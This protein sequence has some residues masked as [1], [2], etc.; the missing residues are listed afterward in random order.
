MALSEYP[1]V[2]ELKE[3]V[4]KHPD[5]VITRDDSLDAGNCESGTDD[6]LEEYFE[7]RDSVKASELKDFIGDYAGVQRVLIYKFSQMENEA[8]GKPAK[9]EEEP[10]EDIPEGK[11]PF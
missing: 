10:S 5:L 8:G 2:E 3:L 11:L 6:F 1:T 7:D 4:I 9:L